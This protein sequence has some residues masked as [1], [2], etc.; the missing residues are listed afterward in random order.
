MKVMATALENL[1]N[2]RRDELEA[3]LIESKEVR[4]N[5]MLG[6]GGNG[7]VHLAMYQNQKVAM[8]TLLR[9]DENTMTRFRFECFLMKELRHP[10]IVKLVGVCWD[11]NMVGLCLEFVPNGTLEHG[12]RQDVV[13][14]M[15]EDLALVGE[16]QEKANSVK[17]HCEN[18]TDGWRNAQELNTFANILEAWSSNTRQDFNE[19][20]AKSFKTYIEDYDWLGKKNKYGYL[21]KFKTITRLPFLAPRCTVYKGVESYIGGGVYINASV[22]CESELVPHDPDFVRG[23]MK[24]SRQLFM[25]VQEKDSTEIRTRVYRY[26]IVDLKLPNIVNIMGQN[27]FVKESGKHMNYTPTLK[28]GLTW[29]GLLH[30]IMHQLAST[31]AYVHQARYYDEKKH[32][33]CN[34]IIHWD[35]KPDNILLTKAFDCK[36]ADFGEARA[37]DKD[38]TMSVVGTPLYVAPEVM[39]S[40][41][42]N[43]TVDSYSF[44]VIM[45]RMNFEI[46]DEFSEMPEPDLTLLSEEDDILYHERASRET[47]TDVEKVRAY[48]VVTVASDSG[49]S[50]SNSFTTGNT[51][52]EQS[53]SGSDRD[54]SS[55]RRESAPVVVYD[56]KKIKAEALLSL[57]VALDLEQAEKDK[58]KERADNEM[59]KRQESEL[60]N[61]QLVQNFKELESAVS[62]NAAEAV[63]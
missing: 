1:S 62:M 27:V 35:L 48:S 24:A 30:N 14:Y 25:P 58:E 6:K 57:A 10:N 28:G 21:N 16:V 2:E 51:V 56:F 7:E 44:G 4:L 63:L 55:F 3:V 18:L 23:N 59:L 15:P 12:L 32:E 61:Q 9:I 41:H 26:V 42:Y 34:Q 22:N 38:F 46:R 5:N 8:K 60:E 33:Y 29:N 11:E 39:K 54:S 43:T 37:V 50:R 36:L 20:K 19:E 52:L 49:G 13:E 53:N 31:M 47:Y 40:E 17:L 45:R